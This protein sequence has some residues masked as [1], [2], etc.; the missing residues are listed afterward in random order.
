MLLS[1]IFENSKV[2]VSDDDI[3][4]IRNSTD[5]DAQNDV[6]RVSTSALAL[7]GKTYNLKYVAAEYNGGALSRTATKDITVTGLK[8]IAEALAF[9]EEVKD[10]KNDSVINVYLWNAE[11]IKP[12]TGKMTSEITVTEAE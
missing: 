3:I 7:F 1:K 8:T 5:S 10:I 4:L 9:A 2:K 11:N 6:V 12:L